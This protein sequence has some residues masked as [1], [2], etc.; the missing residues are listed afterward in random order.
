VTSFAEQIKDKAYEIGFHKI[1]I[2]AA[3]HLLD[4][5]EKLDQWLKKGFHGEMAWLA[6]EPENEPTHK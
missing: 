6:R 4:E 5:A 1:G 2:T 3:E